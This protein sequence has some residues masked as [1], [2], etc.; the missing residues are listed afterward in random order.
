MFGQ[1]SA[2]SRTN[3]KGR[4][5]FQSVDHSL[6]VSTTNDPPPWQLYHA[7]R[8]AWN[9]RTCSISFTK[10]LENGSGFAVTRM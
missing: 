5:L 2:I 6:C 10:D 9:T 7:A 8:N 1:S 3:V 4:W